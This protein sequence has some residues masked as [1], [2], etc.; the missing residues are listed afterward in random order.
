MN[1]IKTRLVK[2][3]NEVEQKPKR[4][5]QEVTDEFNAKYDFNHFDAFSYASALQEELLKYDTSWDV[6]PEK[7][8]P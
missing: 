3:D 5:S 7:A 8:I 6:D 4:T 1:Y 2:A